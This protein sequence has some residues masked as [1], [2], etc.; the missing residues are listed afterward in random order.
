MC[1]HKKH[2]KAEYHEIVAQISPD[3][4]RLNR[5]A[6]DHPIGVTAI[7]TDCDQSGRRQPDR[8]CPSS[9]HGRDAQQSATM[10]LLRLEVQ[11]RKSCLQLLA[12]RVDLEKHFTSVTPKP[13]VIPIK[14]RKLKFRKGN[15]TSNKF[16]SGIGVQKRWGGGFRYRT[17]DRVWRMGSENP[18]A[19]IPVSR[20]DAVPAG[21]LPGRRRWARLLSWSQIEIK[22]VYPMWWRLRRSHGRTSRNGWR[23]WCRLEPLESRHDRFRLGQ[24][25]IGGLVG[26]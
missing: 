5:S 26:G 1:H 21:P 13:W 25:P 16:M 17:C 22:L 7:G 8:I 12:N 19:S 9:V 14:I 15:R 23:L 6:S 2:Y 4:P 24:R 10:K 11:R 3:S 20:G 18:T